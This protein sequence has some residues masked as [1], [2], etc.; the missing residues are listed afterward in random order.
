MAHYF[1]LNQELETW[2]IS[3]ISFLPDK[4]Q[5]SFL[6]IIDNASLTTKRR[7]WDKTK[8][9]MMGLFVDVVTG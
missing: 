9:P 4:H 3:V 2:K 5:S 7:F 8:T 1:P 6:K